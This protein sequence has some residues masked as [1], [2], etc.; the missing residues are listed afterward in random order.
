[1]EEDALGCSCQHCIV[2]Y[3][4]RGQRIG[5]VIRCFFLESDGMSADGIAINGHC[6]RRRSF[7]D[8]V[9]VYTLPLAYCPA[10]ILLASEESLYNQ[11]L[12]KRA[13]KCPCAASKDTI[14][15]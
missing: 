9:T 8:N 7:L 4:Q 3:L 2:V 1:M 15:I 10:N 11:S 6:G 13:H 5:K 14:C 12:E